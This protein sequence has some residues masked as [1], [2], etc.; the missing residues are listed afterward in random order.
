MV[1]DGVG[2]AGQAKFKHRAMS[3]ENEQVNA[4]KKRVPGD[5]YYEF[6]PVRMEPVPV[7]SCA[8]LCEPHTSE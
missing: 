7:S 4:C 3:V 8:T 2:L 1:A 5:D 6:D